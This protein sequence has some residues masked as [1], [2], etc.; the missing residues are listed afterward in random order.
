M[1][2]KVLIVDD[3]DLIHQMYRLV[4]NRYN[5]DFVDAMN[6]REALEILEKSDDI[7]L[8]L[9]DINMPVMNGLQFME[10]ASALG[11]SSRIP[12][13]V[14]STE[15]KEQDTIHALKLGARGYLKK[16]FNSGD[17]YN[18]IEKIL[19]VLPADPSQVLSGFQMASEGC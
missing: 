3:S 11:I 18:L 15:G 19:P 16:P 7:Q 12:V 5:C 8:V 10:K 4:L 17:L 2:K 9:L 6:G 13:L 1:L 14:V